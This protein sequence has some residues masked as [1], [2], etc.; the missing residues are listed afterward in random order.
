M[1]SIMRNIFDFFKTGGVFLITIVSFI[2]IGYFDYVHAQPVIN[3][4]SL[5]AEIVVEEL[6]SPTSMAFMDSNNILVLEKTG[7]VRLISNGIL[8]EQ[9]V[10]NVPVDT[11]SERGLLGIAT[12]EDDNT[13]F[14]YFT[15]SG[16][17]LRNRVYRYNWNGETL[18]NPTLILDLPAIPGPN[19]DGGKLVI[20]PDQY[21]YAIIG[22]LNHDGK[23]Q[24]FL[25]G[26]EPDDTGVIFKVN[27]ND[28]SAAPN[29]PFV[30]SGDS[31]LSRYYA[32]GIR[33]SFGIA[34]DPITNMLW[35][36]ENGPG[37]YDEV[38]LVRPGFNS[39]WQT[40]MGPI[41][42]SGESIDDLVSFQGSQYID[43]VF[44]W[45]I[46]PAVTDIEFLHSQ[47]LGDKYANNIFVGDYNNGNV[48][49]FE[50]NEDRTGIIFDA[51]QTDLIDLVADNEE[52]L[53][54]IIFASGFGSITDIETGPDGFL[55]ILSYD[56][57]I[58]YRIAPSSNNQVAASVI[59]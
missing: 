40:V 16:E 59:P 49:Y 37:E 5:M 6:S 46:T 39:G 30:N 19:H 41:S 56:D 47:K 45:Q 38:N 15:E 33:N 32:Y 42:R 11:E 22:D 17:T 50:V 1:I 13:V 52:E 7:S 27:P 18:V 3:D 26:P 9:P 51:S 10:L 43:P 58:I 29:N 2:F 48:Y 25:D 8:Q 34:I 54:T 21:L 36:T 20:G 14:L 31:V 24:N 44:S 57:G 4:P 35:D 53:S 23:L 55:Y 12:L 28:G